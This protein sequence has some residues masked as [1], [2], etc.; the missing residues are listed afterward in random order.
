MG[1]SEV[2][3]HHGLAYASLPIPGSATASWCLPLLLRP[4]CGHVGLI[5]LSYPR[6]SRDAASMCVG[7]SCLVTILRANEGSKNWA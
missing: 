4:A 1:K 7:S 2:L 6:D 3:P 5:I